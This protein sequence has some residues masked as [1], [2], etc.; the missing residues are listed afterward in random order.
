[1]SYRQPIEWHEECLKNMMAY[2]NTLREELLR[3]Q[4]ELERLDKA[5]V[6]YAFQITEARR[7][8]KAAFDQEKFGRKRGAK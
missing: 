8:G 6:F 5:N 1:M 7:Q 2:T 4:A 3:K